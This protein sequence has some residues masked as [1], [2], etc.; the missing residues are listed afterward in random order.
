M[1]ELLNSCFLVSKRDGT[2]EEKTGEDISR[3]NSSGNLV[4][5][6]SASAVSNNFFLTRKFDQ[7]TASKH[8]GS[9]P[10]IINN[11]N[12]NT[13]RLQNND[14]DIRIKKNR[15]KMAENMHEAALSISFQ[16]KSIGEKVKS[17]D[18]NLEVN[19]RSYDA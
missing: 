19:P 15:K 8:S 6:H 5:D 4:L 9:R 17:F 13:V 18:K 2:A 1:N 14:I 11:S 16:N 10:N 7:S 12:I 3:F